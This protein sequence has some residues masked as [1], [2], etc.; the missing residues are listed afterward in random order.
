MPK[1]LLFL[2]KAVIFLYTQS[3]ELFIAL[4]YIEQEKIHTV[5]IFLK[6]I[7]FRHKF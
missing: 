6:I 2:L 4:H 1:S 5:L 7:A 3:Q